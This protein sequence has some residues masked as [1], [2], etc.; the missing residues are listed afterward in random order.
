M[1][2]GPSRLRKKRGV[3]RSREGGVSEQKGFKIEGF[4]APPGMRGKS[5]VALLAGEIT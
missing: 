3:A 1:G 2:G 4:C 5:L